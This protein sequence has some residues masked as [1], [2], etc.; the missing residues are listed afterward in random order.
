MYGFARLPASDR[1]FLIGNAA[2]KRN[3]TPAVME[4]DYWVVLMLDYLSANRLLPKNY[5]LKVGQV[6]PNAFM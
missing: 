3:L 5:L 2:A 1:K 4:K 6:F